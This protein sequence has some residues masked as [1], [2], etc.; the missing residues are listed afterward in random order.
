MRRISKWGAL[1]QKR[2]N[3]TLNTRE[4]GAS[5][6]YNS[7]ANYEAFRK[8]AQSQADVYANR[9][10]IEKQSIGPGEQFYT[11]GFCYTCSTKRKFVTDY[12]Y[13]VVFENGEKKP[14]W[15]EHLLCPGC[16][17]NNRMRAA[18]QIFEQLLHGSK[19]PAIYITEQTTPLFRWLSDQYINVEGSEYLGNDIPYGMCDNRGIRNESLTQLTWEDNIFDVILSFDVFE[20]IPDYRKALKECARVLRPGGILLFTVPFVSAEE[21]NMVRAHVTDD[22]SIE[23]LLPP[24][25]HGDPVNQAGCLAF[26]H[27][28]WELLEEVRNYGFCQVEALFYWSRELGYLGMDQKIFGAYKPLDS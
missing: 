3:S 24:E 16:G 20:H 25:Y 27:F 13:A 6:E 2:A 19:Q 5:L 23:H 28:G 18:I 17:L 8:Y 1:I 26:Y 15:R 9:E 12:S 14:N 11:E 10:A 22:G 7:I 4:K 21:K